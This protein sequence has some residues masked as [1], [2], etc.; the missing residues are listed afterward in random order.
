VTVIDFA[1]FGDRSKCLEVLFVNYAM[2][3]FLKRIIN[4]KFVIVF[5]CKAF[6]D[7]SSNGFVS[8]MN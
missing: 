8:T 6:T 3:A 4:I 7:L 2:G 5:T 1:G